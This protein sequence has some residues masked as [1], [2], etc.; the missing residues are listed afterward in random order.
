MESLHPR[1]WK[2]FMTKVTQIELA[3]EFPYE[4]MTS[5]PFPLPPTLSHG[6]PVL[7]TT[8]QS[9]VER[10]ALGGLFHSTTTQACVF[11]SFN[12]FKGKKMRVCRSDRKWTGCKYRYYILRSAYYGLM[13]LYRLYILCGIIGQ[14]N[15]CFL[16]VLPMC[17]DMLRCST[18]V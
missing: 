16:F 4:S 1:I 3:A 15:F 17:S 14:V 6:P 10:V 13:Y 18:G 5:L 8:W 11:F 12:V 2:L 9:F 7:D